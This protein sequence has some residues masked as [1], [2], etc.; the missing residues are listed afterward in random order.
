MLPVEEVSELRLREPAGAS[1]TTRVEAASGLA[2]IETTVYVIADDEAYLAVFEDMGRREGITTRLLPDRLPADPDE[3]KGQ[4]PD[5]ES[6]TP[7]APFGDFTH[8]GLIALG[9]GSGDGRHRG[10]FVSFGDDRGIDRVVELDAGPLFSELSKRIPE[11]NLEGT[12]VTRDRFRILQRGNE[13]GS[14]DAHVDLDLGGLCDAVASEGSLGADLLV[15]IA[16]HELGQIHGTKLCFSDAD[17]LPDGTIVFSAS[18]ETT[19]EEVDGAPVGSAVGV[20]THDGEVLALEPIET[21][22]KVE[23]LA[24]RRAGDDI[25][26]FMVTD[27]DDPDR[28]TSLLRTILPAPD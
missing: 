2:I 4:K 16:E 24:A 19:S 14:V 13:P 5:L 25:H 3:R 17:T 28:P 23:G 7:L 8:G 27:V 9:S 22:T 20:M 1:G 12:A 6:L 15:D 10:A 18:A 26:A 11:L 21:E